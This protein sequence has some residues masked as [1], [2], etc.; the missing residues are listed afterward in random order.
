MGRGWRGT[1]IGPTGDGFN[2]DLRCDPTECK[3]LQ[4][5][6]TQFARFAALANRSFS[7]RARCSAR[8]ASI[9]TAFPTLSLPKTSSSLTTKN[10]REF[11]AREGIAQPRLRIRV[12]QSLPIAFQLST[13]ARR[14]EM[15]VSSSGSPR[16]RGPPIVR[17]RPEVCLLSARSIA[18]L[19]RLL[20]VTW[21]NAGA[22]APKKVE[23]LWKTTRKDPT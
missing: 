4:P 17:M 18:A 12:R 23:V 14:V 7:L 11:P 19:S 10:L 15:P 1:V 13:T 8:Q 20:A 6:L 3:G 21:H 2:Q 5:I 9:V 16:R 22:S